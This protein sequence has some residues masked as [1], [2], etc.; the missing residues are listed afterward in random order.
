VLNADRICY[1]EAGEIVEQGSIN[2]LLAING[3]FKALYDL[4][5]GDDGS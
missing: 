1:L 4:Q 5:F 2:E 3:K